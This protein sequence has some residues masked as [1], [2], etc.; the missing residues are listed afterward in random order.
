[1][2]GSN[3]RTRHMGQKVNPIGFRIG[4][5]EDH[6]SRWF[7]PKKAYG[8]FLVEDFKT[9]ARVDEKHNRR[10]PVAAVSDVIIDRTREEVTVTLK[11]ARPGL[12]IGPKRAEVDKLREE[13][14]DLI[15]RKIGP[16][17]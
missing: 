9:C 4:I 11:T 14:E 16:V 15:H 10:P 6:K 13:L 8:E 5:T 1:M 2:S 12:V 3:T 17:K 7:A